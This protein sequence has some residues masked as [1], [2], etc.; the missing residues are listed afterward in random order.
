[1]RESNAPKTQASTRSA[2]ITT[3]IK[4]APDDNPTNVEDYDMQDW[5]Y[6][7][8]PPSYDQ[9]HQPEWLWQLYYMEPYEN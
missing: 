1:M 7:E 4:E 3:Y 5:S 6:S 2:Q 9:V 8:Q